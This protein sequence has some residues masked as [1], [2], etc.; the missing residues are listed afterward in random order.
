MFKI[1]KSSDGQF[2]F[3][4]C[5]SNHKTIITSETYKRKDN[6]I[7]GINSLVKIF[8][9]KKPIIIDKTLK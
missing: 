2:Y 4:V 3:T 6:C 1:N 7:K 9:A 8:G 5:S